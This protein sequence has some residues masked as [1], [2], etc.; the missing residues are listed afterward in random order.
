MNK[1]GWDKID[2]ELWC[3]YC[4]DE[5]LDRCECDDIIPESE[6]DD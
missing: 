6:I 4:S 1:I 3:A 2:P 5:E